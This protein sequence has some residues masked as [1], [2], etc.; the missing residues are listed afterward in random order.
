MRKKLARAGLLLAAWIGVASMFVPLLGG[1]GRLGAQ[2]NPASDKPAPDNKPSAPEEDQ[3]EAP[4]ESAEAVALLEQARQRIRSFQ[5]VKADLTETVLIGPRRFRAEGS[6]LQRGEAE[7]LFEFTLTVKGA[8]G[9][10]LNGSLLEVCNGQILWMSYQVGS[11]VQV[12]RRDIAQIMEAAKQSPSI[13]GEL[14]SSQLG[15]GGIAGLLASLQRSMTFESL[16]EEI[17]DGNPY[18]MIAG[19]WSQ[20]YLRKLKSLGSGEDFVLP[21]YI[22]DRV[23]IFFDVNTDFPRRI[24]YLKSIEGKSQPMLALDFFNVQTN[25]PISND[26]FLFAPPPDVLPQDITQEVISRIKSA[27][28]NRPPAQR[29]QPPGRPEQP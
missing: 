4:A 14:L 13:E 2:D 18:R 5:S 26:A 24:L 11:D 25:V 1:A 7:V 28:G 16:T 12:T 29:E 15:L 6:Y 27:G 3:D 17:V 8:N 21:D 23:R 19:G 22:P 20:K 10:P 9:K